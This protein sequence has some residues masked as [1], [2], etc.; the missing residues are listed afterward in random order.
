MARRPLVS[1]CMPAYNAERWIAEAVDS[2]LSQSFSDFEL[3]ISDNASTDR[4]VEIARAFGDLRIR[5]LESDRNLGH[6]A[7]HVRVLSMAEGDFV[8]FLHADDLLAPGSL[9][10]MVD[11]A[12]ED[13]RIGLVFGKRELRMYEASGA[14]W[15]RMTTI[16]HER[17]SQLRRR[18]DGRVLF[19]QMLLAGFDDNWIGEPSAVLLRR[20]ALE[21][22]GFFNT[23]ILERPDLEL[24]LRILLRYEVGFLDQVVCVH[25]EHEAAW[26]ASDRGP[27]RKWLDSLW[28][29]EGLLADDALGPTRKMVFY[30][31]KQA[32]RAALR[33]QVRRIVK[34]QFTP[35]LLS[36]LAYRLRSSSGGA[37]ALHSPVPALGEAQEVKAPVGAART[38]LGSPAARY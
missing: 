34:R 4:T 29:L 22:C 28:L 9:E 21:E 7:N 3:V 36:Y 23:R 17:F 32:I 12:L 25:R 37:P 38:G 2:A 10:P 8:K 31:R 1:I 15:T 18:N 19:Y 33:A 27:N 5:V 14:E 6:I 20:S 11:L 26:T 30:L 35:E 16:Q 24:Y 13:E